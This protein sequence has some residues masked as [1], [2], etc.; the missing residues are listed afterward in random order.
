MLRSGILIVGGI[1]FIAGWNA[2][3]QE[4]LATPRSA[5]QSSSSAS[6]RKSSAPATGNLPADLPIRVDSEPPLTQPGRQ[7]CAKSQIATFSVDRD[8][9]PPH[10]ISIW[11]SEGSSAF[12]FEAAMY[13]DADGAPNAYHPENMGLDDLSNAGEPGD[14]PGLAKDESGNPI[15]QGPDDPYPGYYVSETSLAD[16]SKSPTDPSRYVDA[17]KV[18]YIVLPGL[19]AR[20]LGARPGD[21]AVVWNIRNAKISYAIFADIGPAGSLGEGSMALAENL[22][23]WSNPRRGGTRGGIVYLVFPGSGNHRPRPLGEINA[24][25]EKLFQSWGGA[26]RLTACGTSQHAQ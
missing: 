6:D 11:Q 7:A 3:G 1:L 18:P 16:R 20:Q 26:A 2:R 13:I 24:E 4:P 12:F 15:V 17:S 5:A 10:E 21:F 25:A 14:W 19:L 23:I 9:A 8:D 22:G